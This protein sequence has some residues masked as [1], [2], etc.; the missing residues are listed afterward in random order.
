DVE[1]HLRQLDGDVDLDTRR[2]REAVEHG[3]ILVACRLRLGGRGDAFAE[4]VE[5]RGDALRRQCCRRS[6]TFF[7][8]LPRYEAG[9]EAARE[10]IAPNEAE[11]LPL[12]GQPEQTLSNHAPTYL[13]PFAK[14]SPR[15][16]PHD[17]STRRQLSCSHGHP[18]DV[19]RGRG[20]RAAPYRSGGGRRGGWAPFCERPR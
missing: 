3:E 4:Q 17:G 6:D 13:P 8:G 9:R 11:D 1:P 18:A 20:P 2:G 19:E 12:F 7:D 14:G 5:R 16:P 15:E 10:R